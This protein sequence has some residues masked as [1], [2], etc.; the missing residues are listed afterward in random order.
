MKN[1]MPVVVKKVIKIILMFA[2][3]LIIWLAGNVFGI[4]YQQS[5]IKYPTS[6]GIASF[7]DLHGEQALTLDNLKAGQAIVC[8]FLFE[9]GAVEVWIENESGEPMTTIERFDRDNSFLFSVPYDGD[10]TMKIIG[11]NTS[12]YISST[13]YEK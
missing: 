5:M 9:R 11:Q 13:T 1:K 3:C 8:A 12:L 6:T 7:Y 2:A 10:Y 4:R